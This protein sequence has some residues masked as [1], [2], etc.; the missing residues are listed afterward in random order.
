LTSRGGEVWYSNFI[1]AIPSVTFVFFVSTQKTFSKNKSRYSLKTKYFIYLIYQFL[2]LVI[3][4]A[5]GQAIYNLLT[6]FALQTVIFENLK[7]VV[8]ILITPITMTINF[9]VMKLLVEKV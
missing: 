9:F 8:K 1:S 6:G 2:L 3:I 7:I 5:A 4:S